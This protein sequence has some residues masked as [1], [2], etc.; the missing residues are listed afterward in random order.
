MFLSQNVS[1][2]ICKCSEWCQVSSTSGHSS[3]ITSIQLQSFPLALTPW[4]PPLQHWLPGHPLSSTDYLATPSPALT[5]WPPPLPHWLPGH[6][7][8]RSDSLATPPPAL[9]P[10]SPPLHHWLL[11]HPFSINHFLSVF[12]NFIALLARVELDRRKDGQCSITQ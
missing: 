1:S 4:P 3:A 11:S 9:T 2:I 6:P 7:L 10:W 8:S 5:H 12:K